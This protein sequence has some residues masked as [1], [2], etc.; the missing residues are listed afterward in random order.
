MVLENAGSSI[1]PAFSLFKDNSTYDIFLD[2]ARVNI[3][4]EFL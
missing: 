4:A 1:L 2:F 3:T